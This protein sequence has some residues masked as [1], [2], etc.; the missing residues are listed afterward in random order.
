MLIAAFR[1]AFD[2]VCL[3]TEETVERHDLLATLA[4]AAQ[5][6]N[7]GHG[8]FFTCFGF[9]CA[10]YNGGLALGELIGGL[11]SIEDHVIDTINFFL[12]GGDEGMVDI[13]D[14]VDDCIRDP[15]GGE[16][17][18]VGELADA[19]ADVG[20]MGDLGEVE[21]ENAVVKNADI[22][23]NRFEVVLGI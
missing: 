10:W 15:V 18:V 22:H 6:I 11:Q 5:H 4:D 20:R 2:D 23:V 21:S 7:A 8:G 12:D 1:E 16:N 17:E 19:T 13:R 3:L 14:V 9:V